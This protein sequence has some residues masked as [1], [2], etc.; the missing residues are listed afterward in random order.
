MRHTARH[1]GKMIL[2]GEDIE[3]MLPWSYSV[4]DIAIRPMHGCASV[5]VA[6]RV[7]ALSRSD[8]ARLHQIVS[9]IMSGLFATCAQAATAPGEDRN[10]VS[11]IAEAYMAQVSRIFSAARAVPQGDEVHVC[12]AFKRAF[13][14]YLGLISG[15]LC[16]EEAAALWEETLASKHIPRTLLADWVQECQRWSAPTA[17]NLGKVYKICPA[18]DAC[19][20]RTLIERHTMVTNYNT[21]DVQ[22]M[23]ELFLIYRDQMLRAYIR[24]PRTRLA[25]RD[26][27]NLPRWSQAYL[28]GRLDEVVTSE[29]HEYLEWEGTATMPPRSPD[30][31]AVWKD[32]G[33]GWD[34]LEIAMSDEKP[35]MHGNMLTRMLVD[36]SAPMPGTRH[37]KGDHVHKIDT[38]PE[39]YK[40][41]AR[42]I[43]SGN[44][45]D[46]LDQSWMEVAVS[47][48]AVNHP[49]YMIGADTAAREARVRALVDRPHDPGMQAL[50]YS[51]DIAGWSPKMPPKVQRGSHEFWGALYGEELFRNAH[52]IN[53]HRV[54]YMN[55]AGYSGWFVNPG[56]NFEGYNGKEMTCILI[57]LLA[58]AVRVWRTACVERNLATTKEASKWSALLLAYIDDGLAKMVLPKSKA[59]VLFELFKV[60]AVRSF[61]DCGFTIEV[62]KCFPSDRFSIFLNEPYLAGRHVV[63]GTRA[64]MT[65]CAE[66]TE[67][68]TTLLERLTSVSTGCRGAVSAGLDP[69]CGSLLQAFHVFRHIREWVRRPNPVAAAVWSFL[70]RNWGGCGLPTAL[71]L[72]TSGG[73]SAFEEGVATIQAWAAVSLPARS[74]FLSCARSELRVRTAMGI[75]NSPLGGSLECGVMME[76]RVP[77]AVRAGLIKLQDRGQ[78]SVLAR[79]FLSYSSPESMSEFAVRVLSGQPGRIIQEQ[80]LADLSATHPHVLFSAFARRI[81][82]SSTLVVLVGQREMT[83]MIKESR[84]DAA[85]SYREAKT[86][87]TL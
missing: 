4:A 42:G 47:D 65:I 36:S 71:Q 67:A 22:A 75:L 83:R 10:K 86:R 7:H 15:P 31:P 50:Y 34:T 77:D 5:M 1:R 20:A 18:P 33:L 11:A 46:R 21:H 78:I 40:D 53:E 28:A 8:L 3:D 43:Y 79:S 27:A 38:K 69:F 17:F 23:A 37:M 9:S 76:S 66:N 73:G 72:G 13:T 55:K 68:H 85:A 61:A 74:A 25:W 58:R 54:V 32:S 62:S 48:V 12:K 56:A 87:C 41:P 84:R 59:V 70:P 30:N 57:A 24:K 45:S 29:I 39:G 64:A 26:P 52:L 81:E 35:R 49:S 2:D 60:C 82:K 63:H 14:Y 44:L 80:L 19:P 51:F 16:S 6:G